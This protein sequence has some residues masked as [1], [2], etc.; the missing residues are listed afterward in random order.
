MKEH[1]ENERRKRL[2]DDETNS[3][4]SKIMNNVEKSF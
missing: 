2:I 4:F 3:I 1:Y